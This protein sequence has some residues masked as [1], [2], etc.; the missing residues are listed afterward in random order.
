MLDL[1]ALAY[2]MDRGIFRFLDAAILMNEYERLGLTGCENAI[3]RID[4]G[5]DI[6]EDVRSIHNAIEMA[7]VKASSLQTPLDEVCD[8]R[9]S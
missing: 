6:V 7:Y 5:Y 3:D 9:D 1:K 4:H 2:E 8:G